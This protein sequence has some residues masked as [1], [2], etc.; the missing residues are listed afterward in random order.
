MS[1][2]ASSNVYWELF[3]VIEV[4]PRVIG[5]KMH[6]ILLVL[7]AARGVQRKAWCA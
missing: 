3:G 4:E 5:S 6:V 7:T 2:Q 1:F